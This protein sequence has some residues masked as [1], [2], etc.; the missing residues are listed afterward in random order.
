MPGTK[1]QG[2]SMQIWLHDLLHLVH[3]IYLKNPVN[4]I[5]KKNKKKSLLYQWYIILLSKKLW[6]WKYV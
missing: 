1:S 4:F 6:E 3:I 2:K 5:V